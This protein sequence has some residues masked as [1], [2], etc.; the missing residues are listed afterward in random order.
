MPLPPTMIV[1]NNNM[2][3]RKAFFL[4][5]EYNGNHIKNFMLLNWKVQRIFVWTYKHAFLM[6]TLTPSL[7]MQGYFS[8]N[9]NPSLCCCTFFLSYKLTHPT[10]L[11]VVV[12]TFIYL[13]WLSGNIYEKFSVW[14]YHWI[15]EYM[16]LYFSSTH[17][18]K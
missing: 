2:F 11:K 12:Y 16:C 6:H 3:L 15:E 8:F 5:L 18:L 13:H 17:L 1:T 4:G 14:F 7:I 9:N 10:T